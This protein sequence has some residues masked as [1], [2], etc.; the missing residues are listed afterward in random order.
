MGVIYHFFSVLRLESRLSPNKFT[1][2]IPIPN[3]ILEI[4]LN[5]VNE[6]LRLNDFFTLRFKTFMMI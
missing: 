6:T 4:S 2:K 3:Q 1:L 5:E